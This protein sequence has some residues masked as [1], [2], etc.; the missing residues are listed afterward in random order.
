[1]HEPGD[2]T[3]AEDLLEAAAI[4]DGSPPPFGI[5]QPVWLKVREL[6]AAV[7]DDLDREADDEAVALDA[8]AL[9]EALRPFV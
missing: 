8:Q 3:T 5:E 1:M 6:A 2:P 9:R 7:R 4:V